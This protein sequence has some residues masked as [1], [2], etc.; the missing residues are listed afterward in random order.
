MQ[1]AHG[2]TIERQEPEVVKTVTLWEATLRRK[3]VKVAVGELH[4]L[5]ATSD[6]LIFAMGDNN[7]TILGVG[8]R[9]GLVTHP[10]PV[11]M[12]EETSRPSTIASLSP[13]E[14]AKTSSFISRSS[15]RSGDDFNSPS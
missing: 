11:L 7:D 13:N 15:L 14:K 9:A 10:R 1:L 2:D 6:G 12:P 3:V 4:T 5:L 8:S